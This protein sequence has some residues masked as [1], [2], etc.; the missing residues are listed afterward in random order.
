V[1]IKVRFH[2]LLNDLN[3]SLDV[4]ENFE[5]AIEDVSRFLNLS[6][7]ELAQYMILVNG[8]IIIRDQRKKLMNGDVLTFV[9]MVSG[10]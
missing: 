7:K 6:L 10:G 1:K 2:G 5:K 8:K 3:L 4:N 9:P